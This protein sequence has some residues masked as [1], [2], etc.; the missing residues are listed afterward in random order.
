MGIAVCTAAVLV[1]AGC[2]ASKPAPVSEGPPPF[3]D[4]KNAPVASRQPVV[5]PKPAPP[6]LVPVPFVPTPAPAPVVVQAPPPALP[7]PV[8]P[9]A[10]KPPPVINPADLP[11]TVVVWDAVQKNVTVNAGDLTA[12]F[13]FSLTNVSAEPVTLVSAPSSCG[14]TVPKLPPLPWVIAPGTAGSFEVNMDLRGK[15][16]TVIKTITFGTDKGTKHLLVQTTITPMPTTAGMVPGS[17]ERNQQMAAADR[18]AVFRGDCASCHANTTNK[19]G[20][21]LYTSVCGVCH[22]AE[23][24]ATSVPD[25]KVARIERNDDY[26]RNWIRNGR[27]GSMMPA[28]A[29]SAGGILDDAQVASLVEY[30]AKTMPAKPDLL[31][32]NSPLLPPPINVPPGH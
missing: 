30:L 26:W 15:M 23:H 5:E 10:V 14:C 21:E 22:E 29:Q 13:L 8:A 20:K 18:Q 24:R 17:R 9:P 32:P 3:P 6:V 7:P 4:A 1:I 2:T 12:K 11:A 16:G 28:F 31:P 27:A 25:L 19:L